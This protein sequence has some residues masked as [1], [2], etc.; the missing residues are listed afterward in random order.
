MNI[1]SFYKKFPTEESCREDF[2]QQREAK[3]IVCYKCGSIHHKWKKNRSQWECKKCGHRTTLRS[4]T[5]MHGS[6]LPFMY[7]Y[8]TMH[9]ITST[10]KSFSALE[11][12][13]QLGH[14]RY[15]P[16]W[17]MLHKLRNVMGQRDSEYQ[18][19]GSI[20]LDEGFFATERDITEKGKPLKRGRGSQTKSKVLVMAESTPVS[21]SKRPVKK[22]VRYIKMLV[23][24]N[25][26]A[27]TINV[28]VSEN[29]I[30]ESDLT[31]DDS[32]SYVNLHKYVKEHVSQVIQPKEV[33]KV[34]PWVHLVISNS[35][36]LLLNTY[37]NVKKEFLQS[38]LNEFC[39][40]FNRRNMNTFDR[41]LVA[42][43]NYET[44]FKHIPYRKSA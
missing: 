19:S 1:I 32:T 21:D 5:V 39:Y 15:Q 17:E 7:W 20:E 26:K 16:I 28:E 13:R 27:D 35:K 42:C 11:L 25:L 6:K 36:R 37:H 29:I 38:Y 18:L 31:T 44:E 40:K 30:N 43:V 12:Q 2:K 10:K 24:P 34:L 3:G 8:I 14:N 9:L 41:L 33:G 4:G 22:S 23:I